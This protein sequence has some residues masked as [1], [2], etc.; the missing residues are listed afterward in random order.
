M[1]KM[2]IYA[3]VSALTLVSLIPMRASVTDFFFPKINNNKKVSDTA[4][5]TR[6]TSQWRILKPGCL[7]ICSCSNPNCPSKEKKE[8][9][10]IVLGIG[11]HNIPQY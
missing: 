2:K 1:K 9:V 5:A 4:L 10:T 11:H 7:L 6:D 8:H 3:F